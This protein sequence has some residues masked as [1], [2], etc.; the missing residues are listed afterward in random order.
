MISILCKYILGISSYINFFYAESISYNKVFV[1][2]IVTTG[3]NVLFIFIYSLII[4]I[5]GNSLGSIIRYKDTLAI[6]L[7]SQIPLLFA[8]YLLAPVEYALFGEYWFTSNPS[9]FV[10]KPMI[11]YILIGLECLMILWSII[12]LVVGLR[13]QSGN[14]LFAIVTSIIFIVVFWGTIF[15]FF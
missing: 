9:P 3:I 10:I 11:S 6:L 15:L 7:Y 12:L 14:T 2:T 1:I 5:V 8:F 4:K 13:T